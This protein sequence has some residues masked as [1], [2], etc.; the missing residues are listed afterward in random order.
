MRRTVRG[1]ICRHRGWWVLRYRE[2]IRE[3]ETIRSIQRSKRLALVDAMHK[4]RKS[5]ALLAETTLEPLNK[6][7]RASSPLVANRLGDFVDDVYLPHVESKRKPSTY[8]GYRQMWLRYLKPRCASALMHDIETRRI[9]QLLDAVAREDGLSPQTVQHIKH[10]L[11]GVF[12]FA[13]SQG[14]LPRGTVNPVAFCEIQTVPDFDGRAY[15]LEEIALMLTVLPEP[16][17]TVVAFAAFTGL[18]AGEVRGLTREAYSPGGETDL[19]VIRV[20]RSVWRGRIGE[21]KN[22]RS[23]APVPL[24]PQLEGILERHR[25]SSGN[26]AS[27]PIF[28]NGA[29]KGLDLDSL[30][31]RQMREPLKRAN[32]EW[33]GWHGF[34]R[35]LATNLERIGVRESIA[36]MILRHANDRVTRKHYIK[37]PSLEAIAAMRRLSEFFSSIEKPELLPTCSPESPSTTQETTSVEWVH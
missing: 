9:Q 2:R 28:M 25:K 27:G 12:T 14:H 1:T 23:K 24:I 33:E 34:R 8:R 37:P 11:G 29:G 35:G 26:P 13:I 5:V 18:R 32:I 6:A 4:T 22:S 20:M 17:R 15:S 21:P 30:Y 10:F 36:A 16:S 31:R 3:G 19:G 7:S